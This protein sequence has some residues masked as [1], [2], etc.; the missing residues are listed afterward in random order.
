MLHKPNGKKIN[1]QKPNTAALQQRE[2]RRLA[3]LEAARDACQRLGGYAMI[4]SRYLV[5]DTE[6]YTITPKPQPAVQRITVGTGNTT[7]NPYSDEDTGI[8]ND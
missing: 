7:D 3:I 1:F 2:E 4:D 6:I 5:V 8:L